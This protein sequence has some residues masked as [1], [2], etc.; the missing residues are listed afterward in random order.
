MLKAG[1]SSRVRADRVGTKCTGCKTVPSVL[2]GSVA[3]VKRTDSCDDHAS[4]LSSDN[5]EQIFSRHVHV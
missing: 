5:I 2:V 1:R 4:E 3:A